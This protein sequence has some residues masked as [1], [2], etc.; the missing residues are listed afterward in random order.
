MGRTSNYIGIPSLDYYCRHF[1]RV[2]HVQLSRGR[3]RRYVLL[4]FFELKC[5]PSRQLRLRH[6]GNRKDAVAVAEDV[7]YRDLLVSRVQLWLCGSWNHRCRRNWSRHLDR[8]RCS[9]NT[10]YTVEGWC[11]HYLL[12]H[13]TDLDAL[14]GNRSRC[15]YQFCSVL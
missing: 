7:L 3:I 1:E 12:C 11:I 2:G 5:V 15:G 10:E 13:K 6:V 4:H 8:F 9:V 14:P